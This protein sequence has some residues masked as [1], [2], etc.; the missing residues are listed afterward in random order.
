VVRAADREHAQRP[1]RGLDRVRQDALV[2]VKHSPTLCRLAHA[3]IV[4]VLFSDRLS[5]MA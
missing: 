2:G 1:E 4:A 3:R 5:R